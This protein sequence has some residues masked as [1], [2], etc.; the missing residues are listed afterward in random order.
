MHDLYLI[1]HYL[2][3][4]VVTMLFSNMEKSTV[5]GEV[6]IYFFQTFPFVRSSVV[7]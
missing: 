5:L 6:M 2:T 7:D 4:A 3:S 1:Q